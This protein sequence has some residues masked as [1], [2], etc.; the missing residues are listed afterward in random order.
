METLSDTAQWNPT[1]RA[2]LYRGRTVPRPPVDVVGKT[3]Q[4]L[5][6]PRIE[7]EW[8]PKRPAEPDRPPKEPFLRY[9]WRSVIG[10]IGRLFISLGMLLF[11]F[12]G[13]QL[14][15]TGLQTAASQKAL[16]KEFA[17]KLQVPVTRPTTTV[18]TTLPPTTLAPT[19]GSGVPTSAAP[20]TT[21]TLPA[22]A[23]LPIPELDEAFASLSIPRIGMKG[24]NEGVILSGVSVEDLKKGVGHFRN[25]PLPGQKGNVALA[26]HRTTYGAPFG[27][28]DKL[29][30]GDPITFTNTFGEKFVYKVTAQTIVAPDDTTVLQ[31]TDV[32]SLTLVT[33]DPKYTSTNRLIIRA[34]L[35]IAASG[36]LRDPTP[37]AAGK[38]EPLPTEEPTTVPTTLVP[39]TTLPGSP[40]TLAP[41]T[42][43]AATTTTAVRAVEGEE[44]LTGAFTN[45]WFS[46]KHAIPQMALWGAICGAIGLGAWLISRRLHRNMIGFLIGIFPF[47][48]ALYFFYENANLLLPP[49]L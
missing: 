20:T 14:W 45:G 40:S 28:L 2:T 3:N 16:R 22:P 27:D 46:D 31:T 1:R 6:L 42:T 8:P 30:N 13:Y 47:L 11:G 38:P 21:T 17:S 15:G 19:A 48:I 35:D 39:V 23:P 18:A 24:D 41:S 5:G 7:F 37:P 49:G 44:D 9:G 26:G 29:Q 43:V 4:E 36:P 25:T 33:C 32:P 34:E 12:V 10:A